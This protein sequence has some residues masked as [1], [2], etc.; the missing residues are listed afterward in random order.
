MIQNSKRRVTLYFR[1]GGT[2]MRLLMTSPCTAASGFEP[3]PEQPSCGPAGRFRP[4]RPDRGKRLEAVQA[5]NSQVGK[6]GE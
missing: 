1:V 6:S 4:V 3:G 5:C 2:P